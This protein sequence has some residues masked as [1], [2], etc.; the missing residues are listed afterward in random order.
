MGA[1]MGENA[2]TD[3]Y[4]LGLRNAKVSA[5]WPPIEW[6]KIPVA[7]GFAGKWAAT[8]C[9]ASA[10]LLGPVATAGFGAFAPPAAGVAGFG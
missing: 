3:L 7:L 5:P 4:C 8:I 1:A 10:T 6:P 9:G 2:E